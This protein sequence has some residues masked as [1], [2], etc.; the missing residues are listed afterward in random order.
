MTRRLFSRLVSGLALSLAAA[1]S[2]TALAAA[3]IALPA[4]ETGL[5]A[6]LA[7]ALQ[8]R[9][10]T[11]AFSTEPLEAKQLSML[12]W[13]AL[14]VNRPD[15]RRVSPTALNR[16][17]IEAYLI[18]QEGAWRYDAAKHALLPMTE[19]SL[20]P[21][22]AGTQKRSQP[23]VMT[24]PAAILFTGDTRKLPA[25]RAETTAATDAGLAAQGALLYCAAANL[26]C[27][28]RTTM[29]GA[30]LAKELGLESGVLPLLNVIA[31]HPVR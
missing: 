3:P 12:F 29:D 6:P 7:A 2:A 31:G 14:G 9:H 20:L 18:T 8:A 16:Q 25:E 30:T 19:K 13:S 24:A 23:Y 21:L 17:E 1:A 26:A 15:G 5:S 10:S 27:V 4:P 11:R 28:P 22:I